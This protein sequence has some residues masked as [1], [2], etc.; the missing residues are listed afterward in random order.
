MLLPILPRM[1]PRML[2]S[3]CEAELQAPAGFS[4]LADVAGVIDLGISILAD[5]A[6]SM[7][8]A[9]ARYA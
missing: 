4:I 5:V 3:L 9:D 2:S 1:L 6:R 7:A 8:L